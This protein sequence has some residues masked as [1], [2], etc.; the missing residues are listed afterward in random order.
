MKL[1]IISDSHGNYPLAVKAVELAGLIDLV[2]HLGDGIEDARIV[3]SISGHPV[4]RVPGNCDLGAQG[5]REILTTLADR[6]TLI[7][8]G[9]RYSV[10]AGLTRLQIRAEELKANVVLYGHTH[11]A[12]IDTIGD[13]LFVNPGCLNVSCRNAS[14]ALLTITSD[15]IAAEIIPL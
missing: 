4:I 15:G 13:I 11:H 9:D 8:H 7:T 1:L 10:K 2:V 12:S 5:E 6:I 3:E 14:F